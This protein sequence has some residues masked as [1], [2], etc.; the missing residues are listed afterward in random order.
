MKGPNFTMDKIKSKQWYLLCGIVALI[1][2]FIIIMVSLFMGQSKGGRPPQRSYKHTL[3]TATSRMTPQ[4]VYM[5]NSRIEYELQRKRLD[6]LETMLQKIIKMNEGKEIK[7]EPVEKISSPSV[8]DLKKDIQQTLLPPQPQTDLLVS[9]D[10]SIPL[11]QVVPIVS[12]FRS[13]GINKTNINLVN[14][15]HN[16]PM[17]TVDNYIPAGAFAPAVVLEGVNASTSVHAQGDP[18]PI[19]VQIT[20][21]AYLPSN[22]RSRL[23]GCF[24]TAAAAGDISSE[25]AYVRLEKLS[26]VEQKTGEVIEISVKGHLVGTDSKSGQRGRLVDRTGPMMRNAAI[27]GFLSG[28]AEFLSQNR[29]P[30]KFLPSGIAESSAVPTGELLG[31]GLAKGTSSALEK[32]A[33]YYIKRAEQ[34]QPIIEVT[35]GMEVSVIFTEGFSLSDSMTRSAISKVND[36]HRYQ[37]LNN[38]SEPERDINTGSS[39]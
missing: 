6:S 28:A 27:G 11:A 9:N 3:A 39:R 5:E 12:A 7:D 25:R 34:M 13:N 22:H 18:R 20:E 30:I 31:Q 16:K 38:M 8:A 37:Q 26:C 33:D 15:R 36:Q 10:R 29:N 17:R 35:A 14:S 4:E 2:I 21:D 24:I 19:T 32:Y 23:K 1:C